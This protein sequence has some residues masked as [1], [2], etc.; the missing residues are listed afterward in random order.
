LLLL[1]A[2]FLLNSLKIVCRVLIIS[3]MY[4]LI[5]FFI[6]KLLTL[7][8]TNMIIFYSHKIFIIIGEYF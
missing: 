8:F 4:K 6:I 1:K 2:M 7:K 3:F 5:T